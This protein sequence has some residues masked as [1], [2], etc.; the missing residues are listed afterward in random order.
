MA[1][2]V[3]V[4]EWLKAILSPDP[5]TFEDAYWNDRP[6]ISEALPRMIDA[7]NVFKDSYARGKLLELLGESGELKVIPILEAELNG[8]DQATREWAENALSA[9]K[10][11]EA[12]QKDIKYL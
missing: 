9:L 4:D 3:S 1:T 6:P 11:G 2:T 7:L 10:R 8:P 5:T 12:W